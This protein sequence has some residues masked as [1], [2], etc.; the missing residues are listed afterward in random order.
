M[1]TINDMYGAAEEEIISFSE[2]SKQGN[3]MGKF[4]TLSVFAAD[5]HREA[6]KQGKAYYCKLT[7]GN[8]NFYNAV[9]LF[10]LSLDRVMEEN[11]K[12]VERFANILYQSNP[13]AFDSMISATQIADAKKEAEEKY[14]RKINF[15]E[16]DNER[17]KHELEESKRIPVQ[18]F[19]GSDDVVEGMR[20][21]MYYSNR[22]G[23]CYYSARINMRKDRILLI[24]D[25]NGAYGGHGKCI[26]ISEFK[27]MLDADDVKGEYCE[28]YNGIIFTKRN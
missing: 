22:L 10:E 28:K 18:T 23:E 15:L 6:I 17:L 21:G 9:P 1:T 3:P 2:K 7:K 27:K 26:D 16:K 13:S 11:P 5:G 8:G 20:E 25:E 19:R 12:L 4:R 24:K 14:A